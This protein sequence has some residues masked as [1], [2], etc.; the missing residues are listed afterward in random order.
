MKRIIQ[1]LRESLAELKK[2][3][4]PTREEVVASTKVVIISTV[5]IAVALWLVDFLIYQ[6]IELIF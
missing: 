6:G 2:V 4:W 1:F 3:V 5:I